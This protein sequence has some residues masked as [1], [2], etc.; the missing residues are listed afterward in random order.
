MLALLPPGRAQADPTIKP[1][2]TGLI[3]TGS[4]SNTLSQLA[5]A[6]VMGI[7]GGLVVQA[8]WKDFQPTSESDFDTT[9]ID[10]AL[11]QTTNDNVTE[12]NAAA[13]KL[14][15]PNNRQIGVRLRIF[16]G[17]S[18]G[19]NDAPEWAMKK[20]TGFPITITAEY[21]DKP[22]ACKLGEFWDTN[23]NYSKAWRNFQKKLAAKYDA[24]PL[25]QEVAVT[26]CTS[27]SAEPFFL[28]L[29][30]P[31]YTKTDPAPNPAPPLPAVAL[32]NAGFTDAAYQECLTKAVDDYAPWQTTR[33]EFSFNGFSGLAG[34]NDV[35]VS[36]RIMRRCRLT[37]GPRCI[38]SNHDLDTAAPSTIL[39]IYA[40]ER[41]FGPNI[42]FQTLHVVPNDFE[43]TLRKGI[44]LGAGSI[45]IWQEPQLGSFEHQ[46][47]VTL[48]N[49]ASMFE[50]Q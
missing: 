47:T 40:F 10:N 27:F 42:T 25:I 44:S 46:S 49:W 37:I 6:Q 41:K 5:N 32:Q 23:S 14:N 18:A 28:N 35:A 38:L 29:K 43:G 13:A 34:Q 16:T 4:T 22:E 20:D 39:P 45:E 12:Y 26:S 15:A 24:N 1:A 36:E 31:Q 17:C 50:P 2:I 8:R 9:V 30:Q 19:E 21:D 3:S 33:L 11:T 7:L 48:A